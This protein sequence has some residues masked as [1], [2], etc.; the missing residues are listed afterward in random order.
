MTRAQKT[1]RAKRAT[2]RSYNSLIID[3]CRPFHGLTSQP[4]SF[5]GLTP[6]ALRCRPLRGLYS[7]SFHDPG[8]HAPGFMLSPRFAG[9]IVAHFAGST[10]VHSAIP[11]LTPQG[12]TPSP[13]SRVYL[14]AAL[15]SVRS[16]SSELR[17]LWACFSFPVLS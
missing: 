13:A 5:L 3:N 1:Q 17:A 11:G 16:V 2:A 8:A 4:S 7:C 14:A 12:F 9:S 10:L 15:A 6:Q